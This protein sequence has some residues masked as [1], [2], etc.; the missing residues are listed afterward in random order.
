MVADVEGWN[1]LRRNAGRLFGLLRYLWEHGLGP[2]CLVESPDYERFLLL[3]QVLL[4][5]LAV[6][7]IVAL[8]SLGNGLEGAFLF[9]DFV[10]DLFFE[11]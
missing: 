10:D 5:V 8:L 7:V 1:A 3:R 2:H 4:R 11:L 6:G 9:L